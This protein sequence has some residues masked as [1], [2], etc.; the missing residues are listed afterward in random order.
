MTIKSKIRKEGIEDSFLILLQGYLHKVN[1]VESCKGHEGYLGKKDRHEIKTSHFREVK[2]NSQ[3]ELLSIIE[4]KSE[5]KF[6]KN[7]N[8]ILSSGLLINKTR[9]SIQMSRLNFFSVFV[10]GGVAV[11]LG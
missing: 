11:Y 2:E 5:S 9:L 10:Y 1:V 7:S 3:P 8:W 6:K 4:R